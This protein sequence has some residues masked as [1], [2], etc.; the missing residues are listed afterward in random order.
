MM[1]DNYTGQPNVRDVETSLC[2]RAFQ[3]FRSAIE[4][5]DT[6]KFLALVTEEFQFSIPLPY[7]D[8]KGKQVGKQRFKELVSFEREALRVKLTPLIELYDVH[9][10]VVVFQA[11]GTLNTQPY[12]NELTVVFEFEGDQIKSFKEFVG[13]P[14]KSYEK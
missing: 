12:R 2:R 4:V 8:W 14:L 11:Q 7:D 3:A 9:F 13:M 6:T 10:G 1:K 5:G